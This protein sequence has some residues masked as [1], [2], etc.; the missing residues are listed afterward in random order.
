MKK[1]L[2]C[3]LPVM[4][5][6]LSFAQTINV[7]GRVSNEKGQPVPF[8]FIADVKSNHAT[9]TDS[10]GTFDLPAE[11]SSK[12]TV[13]AYN[14][15]DTL[16]N[17]N[18]QTN[19]N[20]SL[21]GDGA[22]QAGSKLKTSVVNN[23]D[24]FSSRITTMAAN[25]NAIS[26]TRHQDATRGSRYLY[27]TWVHG[28]V[29][30]AADSIVENIH[31]LF[32]Y[33]KIGG[34]L[35]VNKDNSTILQIDGSSFKTFILF[36]AQA[37]AHPFAKVPAIS[38]QRYVEVISDGPKYKIYKDL[39]TKFH[40]ADFSTN[41]LASTG[42]NYDEYIDQDF[43]YVVKDGGQPV[44]MLLKKKAIKEVFAADADK[45]NKFMSTA[46]SDDIDDNYMKLLGQTMNK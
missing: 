5:G 8:A 29:T 16:V 34:S 44:K 46:G 19:L 17:V 30:S 32:N 22:T 1:L 21:N 36:D 23:Y 27:D 38:P 9:F 15:N 4:A 35:L 18:N 20:I 42:N 24:T 11:A 33:D 3:C 37:K 43:Y 40:K 13:K 39:A 2:L 45:L 28:Y 12:L 41:G 25:T 10:L 26:V 6:T 14:F 7:A 31:Y